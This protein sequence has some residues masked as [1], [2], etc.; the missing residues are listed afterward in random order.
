[1]KLAVITNILA[2][3]RIPLF[4][5]LQRRVE[6]LHV[7]LMA[8]SEENRSWNLPPCSFEYEVLPGLHL[9]LPGADVS[10]HINHGVMRQLREFAPDV[11]LSGGFTPANLSAWLYCRLTRRAFVAWGELTLQ[12]PAAARSL[13]RRSVRR[14]LI[15]QS[16]GAIA[17]SSDARDAFAHY[18]LS[19]TAILT[20]IMPID[21]QYFHSRS[22]ACRAAAG[23]KLE[24]AQY[25][26]PILLSVGRMSAGKGYQELFAIYEAV[27][28]QRPVSLLLVGDGPQ[29][30]EYEAYV[31]SR[32]WSQV[33]F[34]GFRQADDV[35]RFLAL[36]DVFVFHTLHDKFGAVLS[37]AMA[38]ELPV[39]S[40][41][42]ACATRDLVEDGVTGF[43]IDPRDIAASTRT[44][45]EVLAMSAS[46]RSAVGT[47]AYHKVRQYNLELTA[48]RMIEF[49]VS[50]LGRG[51]QQ[52][53]PA[54]R[55]PGNSGGSP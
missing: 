39:V 36:A 9:R 1:M 45:L 34:V 40:S 16:D 3:Y 55:L 44:L 49:M 28:G 53:A 12:E 6:R 27:L 30:A 46:E 5:A 48:E 23:F 14:L 38:A 7:L 50:L 21:V 29:R 17:S 32:G 20:S 4:A 24:R 15:S 42:H 54:Q 11:V 8:E 31:R 18:G 26:P 19:P 43:R 35:A 22:V 2:P 25:A 10:L 33:H 37:E 52:S 13:L 51:T 47:A 41:I